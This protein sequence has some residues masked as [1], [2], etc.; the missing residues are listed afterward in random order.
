MAKA[1]MSASARRRKK[2]IIK[3]YH[4][5]SIGL[6]IISLFLSVIRFRPVF[7]RTLQAIKD[8]GVSLVY[9][10]KEC[11]GD[12]GQITPTVTLVPDNAIEVLPFD[13]IVF[14][15]K[16]SLFFETLV[17]KE[18]AREF[19]LKFIQVTLDISTIIM[20]L[21]LLGFLV[22]LLV[23]LFKK[24]GFINNHFNRD[25]R[26]FVFYKKI[27][28]LTWFKV[29]AFIKSYKKFLENNP[30]YGKLFGWIWAYNLNAMT[31]VL[32]GFAFLL[33][34]AFSWDIVNVLVQVAKL[35]MDTTV[36]ADFLPLWAWI[37]IGWKV[38]DYLRKRIGYVRLR[39]KEAWNRSFLKRFLGGLFLVGKQRSGKTSGITDMAMTQSQIFRDAGK[40][41]FMHRAKQFPYFPWINVQLLYRKGMKRHRLILL[42]NLRRI[43][44]LLKYCFY[45]EQNGTISSADLRAAR[46]KLKKYGYTWSNFIFDYDYNR[47]GLKHN[48]SLT[49]IDVFEAIEAYIQHFYVY[50]AKTSLIMANYPIREDLKWTDYGNMPTYDGDFYDRDSKELEEIST[51]C[52]VMK[53]DAM[54]LGKLVN[55]NDEYKDAVEMGIWVNQ[56]FSKE[57]GNQNTNVGVHKDANESNVKND[58]YEDNIK[59]KTHDATVDNYN[60]SRPLTDDQR[61]D[62]L[63]ADN[64]DLFTIMKVT[65]KSDPKIVMPFYGLELL[66]YKIA[67]KLYDSKYI[68]SAQERGDNTLP[69]YLMKKAYDVLFRH[70][71]RIANTFSVVTLK[72]HISDGESG[73][74]FDDAGKYYLTFKKT[75]AGRYRTDGMKPFYSRKAARSSKGWNDIPCYDSLYMS[76]NNMIEMASHMIN[77]YMKIYEGRVEKPVAEEDAKRRKKS[78]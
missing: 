73:E 11:M 59:T 38:F 13:P 3:T 53:W 32:E 29:K 6:V 36:A 43:V 20:S 57:R 37:L 70:H 35:A 44:R 55:P 71:E 75:Y 65:D 60:Y 47:Y 21:A 14:K 49:M 8:V 7:A 72:L 30:R 78:A 56:E 25:T 54:R 39:L 10:V 9:Y 18:Y 31:I 17:S 33:Y 4:I 27:E 51:Y 76:D 19:L 74:V 1:K 77:R 42:E 41:N 62:A 12:T 66:L 58:M 45:G 2:R 34:F 68:K 50:F 28:D 67:S 26:A 16:L 61:A 24:K 63:S 48:D 15:Q 23:L 52:H 22:G 64:R 69:I 40:D 5:L 46:R